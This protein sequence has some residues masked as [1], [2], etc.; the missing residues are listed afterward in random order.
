LRLLRCVREL[1]SAH[2]GADEHR[3]RHLG[4]LLLGVCVF[5]TNL[6]GESVLTI[7]KNVTEV[8]FALVATDRSGR[9]LPSLS[10]A[11]I[12]VLENGQ[13]VP[14]FELRPA[15]DNPLRVGILL[16][17]SDSTRKTWPQTRN[18]LVGFLKQLM[19]PQDET[20][21]VAFDSKI[22]M[23]RMLNQ[24]QQVGSLIPELRGGGPTALYDA[25]YSVCQ[26]PAFS[27][28]GVPRRSALILFSDGDD[29]LSI[30]GL[31]QAIA[32][33]ESRGVAVYTISVRPK[34]G[35]DSGESVL[36]KLADS[37]GGRAF[38]VKQ[39]CELRAALEVISGELRSYYLLYY[40]PP[41]EVRTREFR[42]V[43]VI[44]TQ[45]TGPVL[46]YRDGYS[47]VPSS[48]EDH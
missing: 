15:G 24:S 13:P 40:Q 19:R 8:G 25:L 18:A 47:I 39:D 3:V 7:H 28:G 20:L 26:H 46:R 35:E 44:P 16:D 2:E 22:E 34:R 42:H 38:V 41:N 11:D 29:N 45:N 5:V 1:G 36:R 48:N 9:S 4:L 37:T 12:E 14:N 17:V 21:I 6:R 30:H 43:R 31:D 27:E 23:Q 32:S 33:A 10:A